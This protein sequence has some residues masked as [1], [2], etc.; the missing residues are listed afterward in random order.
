MMPWNLIGNHLADIRLLKAIGSL[1]ITR[2]PCAALAALFSIPCAVRMVLA[3]P[4]DTKADR[5]IRVDHLR[6]RP[7]N[8][9]ARSKPSEVMSRYSTSAKNFGSTHVAFGFLMGLVSL[10]FG[11]DHGIELLADLAGDG[12]RPSRADLAHVDQLLAFLLA[13]VER[14]DPVGSLTKPMTGNFPFWTVLIFSQ[15]SLRSERY[16]ASA[17]FE[18]MPSQFSLAACSNISCPSPMRCSL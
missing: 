11:T 3:D 12:A 9:L 13:E 15:L 8:E 7:L 1:A 6:E 17:R 5:A 2:H 18:M 10:D 14:G 16:G 4:A